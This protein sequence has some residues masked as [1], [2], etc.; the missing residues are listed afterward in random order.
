[1]ARRVREFDWARTPIG[2]AE[3]WPQSLKT[4]V[5]LMLDCQMPMYIAWGPAHTQIYNDAYCPILGKKHPAALG[6]STPDTWPEIW[7]TIGAMWQEVWKGKAVG[8]D[9]FKLTIE[10]YGYSEDV[11]FN[12]SYSPVRTESGEVGGVLVTFAETTQ[13]V[14]SERRLKEEREKLYTLFM[15]VPAA[16]AVVRGSEMRIELANKPYQALVSRREDEL[17]GRP[18]LSVFPELQDDLATAGYRSA[19]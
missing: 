5:S 3:R 13:K 8:F 7:Q 18:L 6:G 16:V 19:S 4:A 1:M 11:Y 9:G 10:R 2:P 17:I 14:L 12:F 15:Q